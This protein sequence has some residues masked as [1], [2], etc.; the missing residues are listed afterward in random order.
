VR[1]AVACD[2]C[3]PVDALRVT[4]DDRSVYVSL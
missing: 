1:D 4:F 3:V 2:R